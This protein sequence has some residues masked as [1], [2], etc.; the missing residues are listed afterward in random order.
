M[1]VASSEISRFARMRRFGR[2]V[3]LF[4][5]VGLPSFLLAIPLNWVLVEHVELGKPIAYM[6]VLLTQI[7]INF[8]MVRRFVFTPTSARTGKK[9]FV[10]FMVG[11]MAFRGLDWLIYSYTVEN[12]ELANRFY[13]AVQVGNVVL[14]AAIKFLYSKLVF[15]GCTPK[16]NHKVDNLKL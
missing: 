16:L 14:F 1:S 11:I 10:L 15:E 7:S 13:L 2:R 9:Q 5:L 4:I 6:I 12:I 8:F 3:F